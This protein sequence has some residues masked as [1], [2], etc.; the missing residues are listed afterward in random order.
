MLE[1]SWSS[2]LLQWEMYATGSGLQGE[3]R[4]RQLLH[5][6]ESQFMEMVLGLDPQI[7]TRSQ[8]QAMAVIKKMA[9]VPVA[10]GVRRAEMLTFI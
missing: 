5:C 10:M 7:A 2:F 3:D 1:E 9:V 6:C 8:V 4:M